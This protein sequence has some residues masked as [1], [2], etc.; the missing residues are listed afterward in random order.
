MRWFLM[1]HKVLADLLPSPFRTR[2]GRPSANWRK[3]RWKLARLRAC[4][5]EATPCGSASSVM[6]GSAGKKGKTKHLLLPNHLPSTFPGPATSM[7]SRR[8]VTSEA[9][10]GGFIRRLRKQGAHSTLKLGGKGVTPVVKMAPGRCFCF[11]SWN[12][13][14]MEGLPN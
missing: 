1:M 13:V 11:F 12:P 3:W 8:A 10:M 4:R 9:K 6:P 5:R 2:P 7:L 14:P